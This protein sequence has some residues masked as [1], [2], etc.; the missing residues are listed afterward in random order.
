M[1]DQSER[2][3]QKQPTI[4]LNR[5]KGLGAKKRKSLRYTRNIGLGFKTPRETEKAFQK[6]PHLNLNR[7]T[8]SKKKVLRRHR[9][10]GLGFKTPREAIEGTYIDKKCPF[11]GN[12][13]IRG[14]ILTGVVQKMKMQR[15]IVIRRDYLHYIRKYNRFEK[16]HRNMSVHLSP[17]FRD[18]EIGDVVTVGECRPLSKT[19]RFNVLK[20]SKGTSAKKSFKK[21]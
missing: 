10:I 8:G 11:T 12:V 6:Q 3:F 13:S 2:S 1:A 21:F 20:V 7:K 17:C 18:V 15:T 4:F 5:K 16:R 14:R 9:N 19:V